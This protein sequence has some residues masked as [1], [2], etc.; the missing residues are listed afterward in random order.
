MKIFLSLHVVKLNKRVRWERIKVCMWHIIS[1]VLLIVLLVIII[2]EWNIGIAYWNST[3]Q[4]GS[5]K[6]VRQEQGQ[7]QNFTKPHT[8]L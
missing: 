1:V 4:A 7:I 5:G 8:H 2:M 3:T 6:T